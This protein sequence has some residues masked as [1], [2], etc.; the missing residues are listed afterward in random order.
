MLILLTVCISSIV[1]I[2]YIGYSSGQ[3]ALSDSIFNQLISL[4]DSKA[5]Q[6]ETYFKNLG[7]QAMVN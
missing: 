3:Q 7:S 6:I 1:A 2:A 4:R 5:Y